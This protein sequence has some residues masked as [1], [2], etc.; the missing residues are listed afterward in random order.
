MDKPYRK[1]TLLKAI[2]VQN[3]TLEHTRKGV[4]QSWVYENC[5]KEDFYISERTYYRYL[6]LNAKKLLKELYPCET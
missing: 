5:I 6:G 2:K 3:I 1:H 4:P